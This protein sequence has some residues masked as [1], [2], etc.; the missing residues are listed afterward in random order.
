[1]KQVKATYEICYPGCRVALVQ[2]RKKAESIDPKDYDVVVYSIPTLLAMIRTEVEKGVRGEKKRKASGSSTTLPPTAVLKRISTALKLD[3]FGMVI[4]DEAHHMAAAGFMKVLFLFNCR[5]RLFLTATPDRDDGL[6]RE[7]EYLTGPI[8]Y[9]GAERPGAMSCLMVR[10]RVDRPI[11]RR[12]E[13]VA[14]DM[15]VGDSACD[16]RRNLWIASLVRI[17]VRRGRTV[18]LNCARAD[19]QVTPLTRLIHDLLSESGEKPPWRHAMPAPTLD[20][21]A[22][23]LI[24]SEIGT[25]FLKY[26][27]MRKTAANHKKFA[28]VG[29]MYH[30]IETCE[31][32]DARCMTTCRHLICMAC[33]PPTSRSV[34]SKTTKR[35]ARYLCPVCSRIVWKAQLACSTGNM[36][37]WM[38][39]TIASRV[40]EEIELLTRGT[41]DSNML[42]LVGASAEMTLCGPLISAAVSSTENINMFRSLNDLPG[43][44]AILTSSKTAATEEAKRRIPF[45]RVTIAHCSLY[46]DGYDAPLCDCAVFAGGNA[47][48]NSTIQG[49]SRISRQRAGKRFPILI[50]VADMLI[51]D[52]GQMRDGGH[53][54]KTIQNKRTKIFSTR[55][56]VHCEKVEAD[57]GPPSDKWLSTCLSKLPSTPEEAAIHVKAFIDG[58]VNTAYV[59]G[60]RESGVSGA[61][62]AANAEKERLCSIV[63]YDNESSSDEEK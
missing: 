19:A 2:G 54:F 43:V 3:S 46:C 41:C 57:E 60:A 18:L 27:G 38:A 23:S 52:T 12:G 15:L 14:F 24:Q 17:L 61:M 40:D 35:G 13:D 51:N 59:R 25:Q 11:K 9:R 22:T 34:T 42:E 50:D 20:R 16:A 32:T 36:D 56:P 33:V 1:M 55:F 62:E 10:Y 29:S 47:A 8:V 53:I 45:S 63:D 39:H 48:E 4:G 44:Q 6:V 21:D 49:A 30:E 37:T 58:C 26:E 7:L 28:D 5:A 31:E